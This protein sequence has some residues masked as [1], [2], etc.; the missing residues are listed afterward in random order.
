MIRKSGYIL[1][2]TVLFSGVAYAMKTWGW[3]L[4]QKNFGLPAPQGYVTQGFVFLA[5]LFI[6]QNTLFAPYI[7]IYEERDLQTTKKKEGAAR[8]EE[9]AQKHFG[10]YQRAIED[11][12]LRAIRER[13]KMGLNAEAEERLAVVAAREEAGRTLAADLSRI[14]KESVQAKEG[15]LHSVGDLAEVIVSQVIGIRGGASVT[16]STSYAAAKKG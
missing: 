3:A 2:L 8:T 1:V 16:A 14:S 4:F 5:F 11:A 10:K 15:L 7:R 9:E 12:R 13:E 6:L